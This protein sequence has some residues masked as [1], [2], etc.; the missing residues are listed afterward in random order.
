[1]KITNDSMRKKN[2]ASL[3]IIIVKSPIEESINSPS[4]TSQSETMTKAPVRQVWHASRA[5][6]DAIGNIACFEQTLKEKSSNLLVLDKTIISLSCNSEND[7]SVFIPTNNTRQGNN[8]IKSSFERTLMELPEKI[9]Y[10]SFNQHDDN[11]LTDMLDIGYMWHWFFW[12][13]II[14]KSYKHK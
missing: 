13:F 1:M 3:S 12:W 14:N 5:A 4:F 6:L 11:T 9:R 2:R 8:G 7:G 10:K